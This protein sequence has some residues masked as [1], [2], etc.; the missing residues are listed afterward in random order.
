MKGLFR[1]PGSAGRCWRQARATVLS[2]VIIIMTLHLMLGTISETNSHLRDP[3]FGKRADRLNGRYQRLKKQDPVV[4]VSFGTS[5]MGNGL[6]AALIEASAQAEFGCPALVVNFGIPGTGP[7]LQQVYLRRLLKEKIRPNLVI[8]EVFPRH[9]IHMGETPIEM[10][11]S[12]AYRI[13]SEEKNWLQKYHIPLE[14]IEASHRQ[15]WSNPWSELRL[16]LLSY[17]HPQWL[18]VGSIMRWTLADMWGWLPIPS[19]YARDADYQTRREKAYNDIG[20][21]LP[22]FAFG[23]VPI[24][25]LEDTLDLCNQMGIDFILLQMPEG[26]D[27]RCWYTP[28]SQALIH[29]RFE[30]I[31][32]RYH[33]RFV[34][35]SSWV[36][37][38][39]F[40][41]SHHLVASG[42]TL[43][44]ERFARESVIPCLREK[45]LVGA[46]VPIGECRNK[47]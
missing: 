35:A 41:D 5:R 27:F 1:R 37:D 44:S 19:N 26:S 36:P 22:H 6:N 2:T 34:D 24:H 8:F 42:A 31:A 47:P 17:I 7:L 4:V 10:N 21:L 3:L 28:A 29:D 30:E 33:G 15:I 16:Q 20:K 14:D 32:R 23:D 38:G 9:Y 11:D 45:M 25:A 40:F 43:F 13:Q 12:P 46:A 39:N 18:P